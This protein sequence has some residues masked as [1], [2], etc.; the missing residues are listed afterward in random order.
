MSHELRTPLNGILGFAELL[1]YELTNPS[2]QE[3]ARVIQQS[4]E[5]LL[6]LV[7]EILDLAK[8]ESG[9]MRF[10]PVST[11]LADLVKECATLHRGSA[12]AKGIRFE[13]QLA[14]DLP[15]EFRTDPTRLHQILNNLL[16]NAVK[17]TD[18]GE[19]VLQVACLDDC[20]AFT[21]RDTGPGIPP[22]SQAEIFEKFKQLEHFLTREHGGTGLGLAIVRQLAEHMGG[23]VTLQSKVGSGSTFTVYLP[24]NARN[25]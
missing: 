13:L 17:F 4:G 22:E 18:T 7:N 20:I 6:N 2:H 16:S 21:V 14:D 5:H 1:K 15:T 11:R 25:D 24:R 10:K 19:V 8:I 23:R 12:E 9:E 3:Y